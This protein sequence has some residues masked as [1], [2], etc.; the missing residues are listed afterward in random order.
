MSNSLSVN[1]QIEFRLGDLI[2]SGQLQDSDVIYS[3]DD[4]RQLDFGRKRTRD[5]SFDYIKEFEEGM[6]LGGGQSDGFSIED[7]SNNSGVENQSPLRRQNALREDILEDFLK[8]DF[9][10]LL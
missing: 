3:E 4:D 6:F 2:N 8:K 5:D 1:K 9:L 10:L 7:F